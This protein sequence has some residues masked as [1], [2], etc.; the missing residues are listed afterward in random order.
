MR[1]RAVANANREVGV[2]ALCP[3]CA[4]RGDVGRAHEPRASADC[5]RD[6][7]LPRS[8]WLRAPLPWVFGNPQ[9]PGA[10]SHHRR[11]RNLANASIS[12]SVSRDAREATPIP[13]KAGR[14]A[15]KCRASTGTSC[16][17]PSASSPRTYTRSCNASSSEEP[18]SFSTVAKCPI[19]PS[20]SVSYT[21]LT[22]P[23]IYSV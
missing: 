6:P 19:A 20:A 16:D 17:M 4:R 5:A 22:L 13:V 18:A 10:Q 12:M 2:F 14:T 15:P 8:S 23:T 9:A 1:P 21:H 7:Q 11:S 3:S